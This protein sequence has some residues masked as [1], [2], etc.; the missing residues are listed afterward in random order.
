VDVVPTWDP[1]DTAR[2]VPGR[3]TSLA[4]QQDPAGEADHPACPW[5]SMQ[6]IWIAG[7][8][9]ALVVALGTW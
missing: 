1:A 7:V 6:R 9:G 3:S 4:H 2:D 8:A 5:A